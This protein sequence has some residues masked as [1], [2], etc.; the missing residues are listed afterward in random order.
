MI[1]EASTVTYGQA[2]S[3]VTMALQCI[4]AVINHDDNTFTIKSVRRILDNVCFRCIAILIIEFGEFRQ[5]RFDPENPAII[6]KRLDCRDRHFD[7]QTMHALQVRLHLGRSKH[8][9]ITG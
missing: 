5:R 6:C 4:T 8:W 9:K 3:E 1:T 2:T 7:D